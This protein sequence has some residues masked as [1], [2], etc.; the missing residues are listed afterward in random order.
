MMI[1]NEIVFKKINNGW[2]VTCDVTP[3]DASGEHLLFSQ[4]WFFMTFE[5]AIEYLQKHLILDA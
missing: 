5:M 3:M 1:V 2:I 4:P